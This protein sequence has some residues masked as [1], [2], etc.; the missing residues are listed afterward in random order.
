[1]ERLINE[2]ELVSYLEDVGIKRSLWW[3]RGLRRKGSKIPAPP[4]YKPGVTGK[5]YLYSPKEVE[6]WVKKHLLVRA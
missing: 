6:A 2:R 1:M 4:A 3:L 5:H